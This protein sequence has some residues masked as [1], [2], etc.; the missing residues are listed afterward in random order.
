MRLETNIIKAINREFI[1]LFITKMETAEE[2]YFS[3]VINALSEMENWVRSVR[4]EVIT[5]NCIDGFQKGRGIELFHELLDSC[6]FYFEEDGGDHGAMLAEAMRNAQNEPVHPLPLVI[7]NVV[8]LAAEEAEEEEE[9]NIEDIEEEDIEDVEEEEDIEDIED[10][11]EDIENE[12]CKICLL[13][14]STPCEI[15]QTS[16]GVTP[17][18]VH[19]MDCEHIFHLGCIDE[20]MKESTTCPYCR[21]PITYLS[22]IS[23]PN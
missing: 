23:L 17:S 20:W 5:N 9:E 3:Q 21:T 10:V 8:S 15:Q 18:Y 2:A 13:D 4:K 12:Q 11:L 7:S 19:L 6:H 22:I 14:L 1:V 16:F